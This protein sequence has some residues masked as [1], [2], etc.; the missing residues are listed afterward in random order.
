MAASHLFMVRAN[1]APAREDAF[2]RWYD[3]EHVHDVARLPGCVRATRYRV[4]DGLPGDTSYRYLALYEFESE[5][6]LRQ[7]VESVYFQE[8]IRRFDEAWGA[9]TDRV[10]SYYGQVYPPA[11]GGPTA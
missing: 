4:L 8:L 1:V 11:A 7:A 10:R 3:D 2:N 6:A 9:H 5:A